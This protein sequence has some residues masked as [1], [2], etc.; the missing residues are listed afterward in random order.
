MTQESH[1]STQMAEFDRDTVVTP[2]RV[3]DMAGEFTADLRGHWSVGGAL[4]GG[5]LLSVLGRALRE[6]VPD[7]PD[8]LSISVYYVSA[9]D[10]GEATL[11]TRVVRRGGSTVTLAG[12][13][14]QGGQARI[15]A[16][17][18]YGDL[19]AL[20]VGVETTAQPPQLPPVEECF[21]TTAAPPELRKIAPIMERQ[22]LHLDPAYA[23]WAVGAPSGEG[24]IQGW[25]R[26]PEGR[27]PDA[28]SLLF[29]V[30]ALPPVT[31]DLGRPGWAPTL[32][33]TVHVRA[34]PAPGWM[35]VRHAT[36]NVAGGM[37][38]ED[39]EV[40]DSTGRLV[41]QSRQLAR[42]PR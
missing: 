17:A 42:L 39:C 23:G 33:L 11:R 19:S 8:P 40:W 29:T 7:R 28:L 24:V 22:Q 16:L 25:F 13:L 18:T 21:P 30:D 2:V 26:L 10:A 15:T 20:P 12:D 36:R 1:E 27:E 41:A 38:E 37:F 35:M 3:T 31:F 9:A 4:N 32:E 5:Y 6:T 14:E 34:N